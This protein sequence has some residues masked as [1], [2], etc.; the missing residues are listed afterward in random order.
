MATD[1]PDIDV[2]ARHIEHL[3]RQDLNRVEDLIHQVERTRGDPDAAGRLQ[4]LVSAARAALGAEAD[5]WLLL[6]PAPGAKSP[7]EA[8]LEGDGTA[9]EAALKRLP[10]R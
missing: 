3:L 10:G 8:A 5:R 6:A 4:Q 2:L 7:L 1:I 9:I